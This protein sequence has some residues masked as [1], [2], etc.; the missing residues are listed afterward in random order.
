MSVP[1]EEM[2]RQRRVPV[3]RPAVQQLA[4]PPP[5]PAPAPQPGVPPT[6][7]VPPNNNTVAVDRAG[8]ASV[9]TMAPTR[10]PAAAALA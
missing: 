10:T 6:T 1:A 8:R 9:A 3:A 2:E 7:V 5:T 4:L